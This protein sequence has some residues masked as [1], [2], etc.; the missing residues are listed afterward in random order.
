MLTLSNRNL[1][2][3]VDRLVP[4]IAERLAALPRPVHVGTDLDQLLNETEAAKILD[5]RPATLCTWRC[6]GTGP[7]FLRLG[8]KLKPP[9][10][11]RLGDV[12]KFRDARAVNPGG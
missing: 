3:L 6:R 9:V 2:H 11:Y 12:L 5:L 4:E 7:R 1:S 8:D 10:R